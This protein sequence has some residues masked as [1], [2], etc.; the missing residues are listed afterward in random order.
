MIDGLPDGEILRSSGR[1]EGVFRPESLEL[2]EKVAS[3]V[4]P[5][6][7]RVTAL[8]GDR[9][10]AERMIVLNCIRRVD[11]SKGYL[12]NYLAANVFS[13]I[14]LGV[15]LQSEHPEEVG[16]LFYERRDV[17]S[18]TFYDILNIDSWTEKKSA[19]LPTPMIDGLFIRTIAEKKKLVNYKPDFNHNR[20]FYTQTESVAE[21]AQLVGDVLLE[22]HDT[23]DIQTVVDSVFGKDSHLADDYRELSEVMNGVRNGTKSKDEF[24]RDI[25]IG[26]EENDYDRQY[27]EESPDTDE[28]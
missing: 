6:I 16:N 23:V 28:V 21:M 4:T 26:S 20:S 14:A 13:A 12:K 17:G 27:D 1:R 10:K 3:A 25:S 2:I 5:E 15:L 11:Q 22:M 24:Y 8:V 19:N 18:N 9:T 7:N